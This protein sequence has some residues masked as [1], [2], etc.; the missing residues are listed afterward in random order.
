MADRIK[1]WHAAGLWTD[2]Q[3]LAAVGRGW[4]SQ[5]QADDILEAWSP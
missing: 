4:L 1:A 5:D 2:Q 3:V